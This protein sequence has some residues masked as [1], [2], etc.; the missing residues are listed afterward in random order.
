MSQNVDFEAF[1]TYYYY[2]KAHPKWES[3]VDKEGAIAEY[4]AFLVIVGVCSLGGEDEV[5]H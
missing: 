2:S 3:T 5:C 4:M 1:F